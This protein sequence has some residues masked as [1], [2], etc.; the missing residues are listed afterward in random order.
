MKKILIPLFITINSSILFAQSSL[1]IEGTVINNT[2]Q[3][4]WG[5]INIPRN[6]PTNF[7]YRNNSVTSVNSSGYLLQAGDE[8]I[9]SANN[10]LN[11]QIITGNKF[12]WNGTDKTSI[13]HGIF[14][15]FN[16]NAIV[17]YN[18]LNKVPMGIIR[19]SNGMTNTSG[20][21]SYNI[22][23]KTQAVAVVVKGMNGVNIY[24]NTFYSDQPVYT[25]PGAGTWR[26][27]VDIYINTDITPN[28]SSTGAKIKNN[29]FYTKYQIFNIYIYEAACLTGFESDYN[30]FYCESGTPMFNYLG[31]SKT[32]AQWQALGYDLHSVVIN[33]DFLNFTDFVPSA[34]LDYGTNLGSSWQAGLSVNAVW[35]T[36]DPA[37]TNQNGSWQVGARTYDVNSITTYY[38]SSVVENL[39]PAILEMTYNLSLANIVPSPSSFNVQVNSVN[40]TVNSVSIVGSKVRLTLSQAIVYGDVVT[41]AYTK[42]AINP[43]QTPSG[44]QAISIGAQPVVNNCINIKPDIKESVIFYRDKKDGTY[45]IK[46]INPLQNESNK[47][48]IVN[49]SGKKVYDDILLKKEVTRQFN[50]NYLDTGIYIL[51]I[52]GNGVL[53]RKKFI[54]I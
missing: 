31:S 26:G 41:V 47:I 13:T 34:R 6:V 19:K 2:E 3:G 16:I 4:T 21:V 46:I 8:G 52:I 18:Y 32:F 14:T 36:T 45:W 30:V 43:L 38:L 54:K 29:I 53:V 17:K 25:G 28:G 39:S 42:P 50:L 22:V 27:I 33:P 44:E 7:I 49:I 9:S 24:N 51:T 48:S 37:T 15:G 11:G 10:N 5:G 35:G 12:I 20:G 1:T 40:R 23:N